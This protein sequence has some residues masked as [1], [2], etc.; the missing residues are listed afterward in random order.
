MNEEELQKLY[1]EWCRQERRYEIG[2]ILISKTIK[3]MIFEMLDDVYRVGY[4]NG[5]GD[6]YNSYD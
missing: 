4:D 2:G 5:S 6:N 3:E 1:S